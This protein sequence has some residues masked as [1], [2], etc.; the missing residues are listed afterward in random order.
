MAPVLISRDSLDYERR[1]RIIGEDQHKAAIRA[2]VRELMRTGGGRGNL[3]ATARASSAQ[4]L[5][6]EKGASRESVLKIV[7]WTKDRAS[8]LSQA[9]Y[10]S[11]T[12][13]NDPPS[14]A[15]VMINEEGR[16]LDGAGIAA[17]VKSWNLKTDAENLSPAARAAT[18]QERRR[19][20]P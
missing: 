6:S 8:P 17:E 15:L 11:R 2:R 19:A 14:G 10:A 5:G 16:E 13:E 9:K 20:M 4:H 3:D 7:S 1:G 12:R 18:P